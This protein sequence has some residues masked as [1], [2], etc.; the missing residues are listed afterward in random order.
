MGRSEQRENHR[1]IELL[2][3]LLSPSNPHVW[4]LSA[5]FGPHLHLLF[6]RDRCGTR[7]NYVIMACY[8]AIT[9][10]DVGDCLFKER[11][12][13]AE[14]VRFHT[15]GWETR[16]G[17]AAA[18]WRPLKGSPTAPCADRRPMGLGSDPSVKSH[19]P[20]VKKHGRT[21]R[22]VLCIQRGTTER[23]ARK[24]EK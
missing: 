12:E 11:W 4:R 19:Q 5:T 7:T 20:I 14:V 1:S 23:S 13:W 3:C 17:P 24:K 6:Q 2:C 10:L 15:P 9:E 21:L 16:A 22:P 18:E 8:N